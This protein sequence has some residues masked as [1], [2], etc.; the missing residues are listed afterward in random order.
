LKNKL[1]NLKEYNSQE[2]GHIVAL[3]MI[4]KLL[5][6]FYEKKKSRHRSFG[7]PSKTIRSE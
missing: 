5:A 3:V 6:F 4:M 7:D 2:F 1:R